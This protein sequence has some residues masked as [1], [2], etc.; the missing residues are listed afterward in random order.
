MISLQSALSAQARRNRKL[1]S[2][3]SYLGPSVS[4]KVVP[5]RIDVKGPASAD[6][7][8]AVVGLGAEAASTAISSLASLAKIGELDHLG[9]GGDDLLRS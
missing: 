2:E 7:L 5:L 9:G 3:A 4:S 8:D 1:L 6:Q